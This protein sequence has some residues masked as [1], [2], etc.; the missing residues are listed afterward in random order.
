MKLDLD[1][2]TPPNFKADPTF[3]ERISGR[4]EVRNV[5]RRAMGRAGIVERWKHG[6]RKEGCKHTEDGKDLAVRRCPI[7]HVK[8]LPKAVVRPLTWHDLRDTT[9]SLLLGAGVPMAVVQRIL[10][11]ADPRITSE[12]YAHLEQDYLG[13]EMRK[14]SLIPPSKNPGQTRGEATAEG[15]ATAIRKRQ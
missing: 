12:R 2:P 13:V 6:C 9:A 11:H 7:H 15:A 1:E 8:L 5:L 4:R 3:V 10:G 14:L